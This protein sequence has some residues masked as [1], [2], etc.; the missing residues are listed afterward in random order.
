MLQREL[1]RHFPRA[2]VKE[3]F[4]HWGELRRLL[5]PVHRNAHRRR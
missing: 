1:L 4:H 3:T 2:R 5:H